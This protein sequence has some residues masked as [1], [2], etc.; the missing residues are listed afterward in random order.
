MT[1]GH[2][3]GV[4]SDGG[5]LLGR[6]GVEHR[7]EEG[8]RSPLDAKRLDDPAGVAAMAQLGGGRTQAPN[9]ANKGS[10]SA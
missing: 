3:D 10:E 6:G 4:G 5:L 8:G 1:S 2:S 9:V 7:W